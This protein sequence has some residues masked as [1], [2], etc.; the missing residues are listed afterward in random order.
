MRN[1]A[2]FGLAFQRASFALLAFAGL[3]LLV[4]PIAY[5]KDAPS[6]DKGQLLSMGT[7]PCGT[8]QSKNESVA[9]ELLGTDSDHTRTQE[10]LCQEYV[11]QTD[12]IVYRIRP[13]DEK[14]PVLLPVGES[15]ELRIQK[16][17][18]F[19]RVPEAGNKEFEYT[20]LSMQLRQDLKPAKNPQ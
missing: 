11:L 4:A 2:E 3:L 7:A 5:S 8:S 1:A 17:K 9:G 13:K 15:V 14:H 16:D 6:Y 20:V 19:L 12:R 10:V 18:L